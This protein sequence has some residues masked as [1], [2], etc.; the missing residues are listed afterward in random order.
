MLPAD[1]KNA[2]EHQDIPMGPEKILVPILFF[3]YGEGGVIV[4]DNR[5]NEHGTIFVEF[6][7]CFIYL[8]SFFLVGGDRRGSVS[9]KK[10]KS[11]DLVVSDVEFLF[12]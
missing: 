1:F 9:F 2:A 8:L 10:Y 6:L 7:C 4:W 5:K 12:Y 3:L 11:V